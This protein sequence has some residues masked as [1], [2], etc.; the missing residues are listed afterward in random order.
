MKRIRIVALIAAVFFMI[1]TAIY[2]AGSGSGGNKKKEGY[3]EVVV[4]NQT[5]PGNSIITEPSLTKISVPKDTVH[6]NA[7]TDY[8]EVVNKMNKSTIYEKEVIL[9]DHIIEKSQT[10]KSPYG[11]AHVV[12]E[13][14]RAMSVEVSIP[15]GVAGAL[16]V[17]N[18]VDV[19]YTGNF[20]YTVFSRPK[21]SRGEEEPA[22][23]QE[24][25]KHFA[26]LLIQDVKVIA[27]GSDIIN[28]SDVSGSQSKADYKTVTLEL[29]PEE[30]AKV[31]FAT[32]DGEVWLGLR[33][34][35]DHEQSDF[36]YILIDDLID[37][38]KLIESLKQEFER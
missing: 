4:A 25:D 14:K 27:I 17:G 7:V 15:Q 6:P 37:K 24:L 33:S 38:T 32:T 13:K 34:Q 10:D 20:K 1:L 26:K 30:Y 18:Y 8:S 28:G 19:Y 12:T 36:D 29:T 9:K 16:K 5:I 23:K 3:V 2:L 11:L 35:G 22:Q 21:T 31:A